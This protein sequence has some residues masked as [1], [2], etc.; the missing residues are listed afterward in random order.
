M[1]WNETFI[2][3]NHSK[4]FLNVSWLTAFDIFGVALVQSVAAADFADSDT[5]FS[6][7][8]NPVRVLNSL[9]HACI[10]HVYNTEHKKTPADTLKGAK[11]Q[12][13]GVLYD[14]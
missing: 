2:F 3:S 10:I 9:S 1:F 4:I 7:L 6:V 5:F 13:F 14:A 11:R 8:F 12:E